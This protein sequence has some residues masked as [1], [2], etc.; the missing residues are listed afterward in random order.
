MAALYARLYEMLSHRSSR[1]CRAHH[2]SLMTG[3]VF[4]KQ[5]DGASSGLRRG[6]QGILLLISAFLCCKNRGQE[7]MGIP[8]IKDFL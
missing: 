8:D 6:L 3:D 7:F 5:L 1:N 4:G 2:Y